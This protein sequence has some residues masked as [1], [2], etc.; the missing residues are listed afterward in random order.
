MSDTWTRAGVLIGLVGAVSGLVVVPEVRTYL[1]LQEIRSAPPPPPPKVVPDSFTER[2]ERRKVVVYQR[3]VDVHHPEWT[4]T[5]ISISK[6]QV[7]SITASGSFRW[8]TKLPAVGPAGTSWKAHQLEAS[9]QFPLP[10]EP[11]ASL[12]AKV[13]EFTFPV[14][15][16]GVVGPGVEGELLLGINERWLPGMWKDNW[17]LLRTSIHVETITT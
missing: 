6:N 13:G 17:G 3:E 7:V 10:N 2:R 16:S 11:C 1:G 9:H 4:R 5:G 14:G 8:D 15:S 12:I